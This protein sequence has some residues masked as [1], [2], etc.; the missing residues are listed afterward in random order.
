MTPQ[1]SLFKGLLITPHQASTKSYIFGIYCSHVPIARGYCFGTQ[2]KSTVS[3]HLWFII[4]SHWIKNSTSQ[5]PDYIMYRKVIILLLEREQWLRKMVIINLYSSHWPA[6]LS[7]FHSQLN[8]KDVFIPYKRS[9]FQR[10]I[11]FA[12]FVVIYQKHNL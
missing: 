4:T 7:I 12:F 2:T 1:N 11:P 10:K 6:F 9:V 8:V 3:S 5:V